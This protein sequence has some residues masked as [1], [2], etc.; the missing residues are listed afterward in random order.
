MLIQILAEF[1]RERSPLSSRELA[2]RF[3]KDLAVVEGMLETLVRSGRLVELG[4]D[5]L[6]GQ[7]PAQRLCIVLPLEGRRFCLVPGEGGNSQQ[8]MELAGK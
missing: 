2:S 5:R 6:C 1:D 7:C 8:K 4:N 3:D